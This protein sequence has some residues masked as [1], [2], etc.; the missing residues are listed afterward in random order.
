MPINKNEITKEMLEKAM[1]C[2]TAE[3]LIAYAKTEGV[4]I[5]KEE[6]EAYLDE[7]SECELKD[8]DLKH[9][10]GGASD[11]RGKLFRGCF[12][13]MKNDGGDLWKSNRFAMQRFAFYMQARRF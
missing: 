6:A 10:A 11:T 3:D 12:I 8:G 5:T 2:N 7:L 9:V 4:D 13:I 1:Q